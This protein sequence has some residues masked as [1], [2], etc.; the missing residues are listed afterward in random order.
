LTTGAC[1][2][3]Y[4][5]KSQAPTLFLHTALTIVLLSMPKFPILFT[6]VTLP[7]F[8]TN[9]CFTIHFSLCK[10]LTY[11]ATRLCTAV[12]PSDMRVKFT[13]CIFPAYYC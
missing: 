5:S 2:K 8:C 13:Y 12:P 11:F 3:L 1:P 6:Y 9:L 10:L 4:K 7:K